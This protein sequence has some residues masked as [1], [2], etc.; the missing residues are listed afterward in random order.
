MCLCLN[1]QP[2]TIILMYQPSPAASL[3]FQWP[4]PL[5]G[6]HQV[7]FRWICNAGPAPGPGGGGIALPNR[8]IPIRQACSTF[9]S[10][11]ASAFISL[12]PAAGVVVLWPAFTRSLIWRG[13]MFLFALAGIFL[14]TVYSTAAP[15]VDD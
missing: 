6:A 15:P 14:Q 5:V 1:H 11:L 10:Q 2:A 4:Q 8:F 12:A 3:F 7:Q 9:T 13:T